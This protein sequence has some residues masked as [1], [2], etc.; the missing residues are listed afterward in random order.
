MEIKKTE[1]NCIRITLSVNNSMAPIRLEAK[2][3]S[4]E[5]IELFIKK[6]KKHDKNLSIRNACDWLNGIASFT[7]KYRDYRPCNDSY[8]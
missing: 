5:T 8:T 7:L 4:K 3:E 2:S 1:R 6:K